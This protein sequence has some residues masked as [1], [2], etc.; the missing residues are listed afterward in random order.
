M[1]TS[2]RAHTNAHIIKSY[3][4]VESR[5]KRLSQGTRTFLTVGHIIYEPLQR[6]L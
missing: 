6:T 5:K 1:Y 4:D 2:A 3:K